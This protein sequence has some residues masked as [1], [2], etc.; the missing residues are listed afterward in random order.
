LGILVRD[1]LRSQAF[2]D[3]LPGLAA[4]VGAEGAR[5]RDGDPHPLRIAGIK[6][7]GVQAHAAR[8]RLPL[9]ASA[10]AAQAGEFLPVLAA[11]GGAEDGGVFPAGVRALDDLPE[12]AARLRCINAI[13][14]SRR[15]FE[16]IHLPARK[17]RTADIPLL[18]LAVRRKNECAFACTYEYSYC[19][20]C[21]S[22]LT[23]LCR[24]SA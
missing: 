10:V 1:V 24:F 7:N 11:V 6:N 8:A 23:E 20:H 2:V 19:A 21:S 5:R 3:R 4:V 16:V 12:P 17:M 13:G 22:P 9:G 14:V 18:A 15:A